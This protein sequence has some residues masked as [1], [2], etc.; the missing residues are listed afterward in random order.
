MNE[1]KKSQDT[2]LKDELNLIY[3]LNII[4]KKKYLILIPFIFFF[5][6]GYFKYKSIPTE[7]T[8]KCILLDDDAGSSTN[9]NILNIA[10]LT[11]LGTNNNSTSDILPMLFSNKTFLISLL[12]DS[13]NNENNIKTTLSNYLL[14]PTKEIGFF[15]TIKSEKKI[16]KSLVEVSNKNL[17]KKVNFNKNI[18]ELTS[19]EESVIEILKSKIKFTKI[20]R[21][22]TIS[23]TTSN[24]KISAEVT[25]L[26]LDKLI[27]YL[28]KDKTQ[29]QLDNV[30]FLNARL[31]ETKNKLR[32]NRITAAEFSDTYY[33]VIYE[34]IKSNQ[35]Q[36]QN[37]TSITLNTY[38]LL[39]SQL[40]Q[41]NIDLKKQTPL[42]TIFEPIFIPNIPDLKSSKTV[43]INSFIG[44]ILGFILVIMSLILDF[45]KHNSKIKFN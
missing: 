38:N 33:G 4:W 13:I 1:N 9:A 3:I 8:A 43:I 36:L 18:L 44:I 6:K 19:E 27:A 7:Y 5:L 15:Q 29:K 23:A 31:E 2:F 11:G 22:I 17:F 25:A 24:S 45:F 20:G 16:N 10:N 41:A 37:E 30:N 21:Q 12:K 26:L 42:F 28:T 35:S 39:A 34:T 40:E 32:K 14:T